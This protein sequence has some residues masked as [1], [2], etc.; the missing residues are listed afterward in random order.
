[1]RYEFECGKCGEMVEQAFRMGEA[2]E[3]VKCPSCGKIASRVFS[4]V[5]LKIN[6]GINRT[7]TFGEN[8]KSQNQKAAKR[9]KGRKAPVRT[10]AHD[11]GGGDI[12]GV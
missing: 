10:V 12:R 2:P 3:K 4:S 6:G 9:M 8:M 11:Y 1:M 7:S 5:A